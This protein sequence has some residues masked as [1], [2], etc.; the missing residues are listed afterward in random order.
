MNMR[1]LTPDF[2]DIL[3]EGFKEFFDKEVCQD[4]LISEYLIPVFIGKL[5]EQG[6]MNVKVLRTDDI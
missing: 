3:E 2:L 1:G 6:K 5:L 4:P